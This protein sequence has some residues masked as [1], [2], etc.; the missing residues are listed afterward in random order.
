[1]GLVSSFFRQTV[2]EGPSFLFPLSSFLVHPADG[3]GG[4]LFP[5]SSSRRC[6]SC[7]LLLINMD[8]T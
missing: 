5:H 7:S 8:V 2:Q 6:R 1:M 3:A 4:T